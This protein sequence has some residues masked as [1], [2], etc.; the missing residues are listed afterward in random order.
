MSDEIGAVWPATWENQHVIEREALSFILTEDEISKHVI[1]G[2]PVY[3]DSTAAVVIVATDRRLLLVDNAE[4]Q[5]MPFN[6]LRYIV[7]KHRSYIAFTDGSGA[8]LRR[9]CVGGMEGTYFAFAIPTENDAAVALTDY[10][11]SRIPRSKADQVLEERR[12]TARVRRAASK[13]ALS[14]KPIS[15]SSRIMAGSGGAEGSR[16]G[17]LSGR[18]V[19]V[20]AIAVVLVALVLVGSCDDKCSSLGRSVNPGGSNS[21]SADERVY[22]VTNCYDDRADRNPA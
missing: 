2:I 15:P 20:I 5:V 4:C 12:H 7:F 11:Q 13:A 10:V 16:N 8:V 6:D 17:G 9:I 22:F 18:A 1:D 21:L 3:G 14:E 19:A